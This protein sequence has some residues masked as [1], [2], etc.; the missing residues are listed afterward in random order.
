MSA[1][2]EEGTDRAWAL[3][4]SAGSLEHGTIRGAAGDGQIV[5]GTDARKRNQ[6][7]SVDIR[8]Q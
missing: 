5:K 2:R 1:Q 7:C 8:A 6:A 3:V 4:R